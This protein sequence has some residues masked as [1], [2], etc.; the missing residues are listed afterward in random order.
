M[1]WGRGGDPF[2]RS[3]E[4]PSCVTRDKGVETIAASADIYSARARRQEILNTSLCT[5]VTVGW[6]HQ[7]A[8]FPGSPSFHAISK[9]MTFDPARKEKRRESLGDFLT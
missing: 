8:S 4:Q 9:R 2:K 6:C 3:V 1:C 5:Y 7:V